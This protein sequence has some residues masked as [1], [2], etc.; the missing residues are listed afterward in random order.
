MRVNYQ[1]K[2]EEIIEG[3]EKEGREPLFFYIAAALL[4]VVMSWNI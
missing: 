3:L 1:K 4:A 2:L